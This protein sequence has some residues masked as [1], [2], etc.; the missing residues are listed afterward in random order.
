[1][2]PGFPVASIFFA[3]FTVS[4]NLQH[5]AQKSLHEQS[6]AIP[7]ECTGV[8]LQLEPGPFST[9]DTSDHRS[10]MQS[11]PEFQFSR[12][13]TQSLLQVLGMVAHLSNNSSSKFRHQ[14]CMVVSFLRNT[15]NR[16]K[17]VR[18]ERGANKLLQGSPARLTNYGLSKRRRDK[19][20]S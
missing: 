20:T 7:F 8:D 12:I 16:Y 10:A 2:N 15:G 3:T 13:R 4:P 1:M 9:Q 18:K 5:Q 14:Q 6:R 17:W 11:N 19:G